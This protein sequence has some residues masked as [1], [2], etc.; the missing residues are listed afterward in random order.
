MRTC[1]TL[2]LMSVL[3]TAG[4]AYQKALA[5]PTSDLEAIEALYAD[6]RQAV[7][8]ADIPAYVAVLHEDVRLLPP[9]ADPI[10]GSV[11]YGRFL[12]PVFEAADYRIE[13]LRPPVIEV[14]GDVALA[15]Y[16]YVIHLQLKDTTVGVAQAGA[17]T[18]E[19]TAARYVD[20]L[21]RNA[22]GQWAV[23]RHA[24]QDLAL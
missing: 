7:A 15:E 8:T 13:V 19:R 21:R 16:D 9:G 20:V 4:L 23:Y 17:L 2:A 12:V 14:L 11:N 22:T 3:L 10:V 18:A 24:W 1:T 6:W 5:E